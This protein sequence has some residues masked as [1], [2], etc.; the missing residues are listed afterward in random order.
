MWPD[1]TEETHASN[2]R[3]E[4]GQGAPNERPEHPVVTV[5]MRSERLAYLALTSCDDTA[6]S[7][8]CAMSKVV[9]QPVG[10]P[11]WTPRLVQTE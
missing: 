7:T 1:W 3:G 4:A 11:P 6:L 5:P 8:V 2:P 10:A 9:E